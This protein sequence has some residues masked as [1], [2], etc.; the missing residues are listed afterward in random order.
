MEKYIFTL[1]PPLSQ[2]VVKTENLSWSKRKIKLW[3]ESTGPGL[4]KVDWEW[5][6]ISEN[7]LEWHYYG[8]HLI[9]LNGC[10]VM[11]QH[12]MGK[13]LIVLHNINTISTLGVGTS[14]V[15]YIY[16]REVFLLNVF[17]LYYL[18]ELLSVLGMIYTYTGNGG[19][20]TWDQKTLRWKRMYLF[21]SYRQ[22]AVKSD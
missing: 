9:C 11:T 19:L 17:S 20:T 10:L 13:E 4:C 16:F 1:L 22:R 6:G 5:L 3:T 18:W 21:T 14:L 12:T 7:C 8:T 2:R 15:N